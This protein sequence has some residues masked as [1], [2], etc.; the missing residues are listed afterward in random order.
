MSRQDSSK[1]R[2]VK[3]MLKTGVDGRGIATIEKTGTVGLVDTYT[4]TLDDGSKST[5]TVTNGSSIASIEKTSTVGLVDTYTIT[6][7]D[8]S[9]STFTVT[10]GEGG[11]LLPHIIVISET[12]STVTLTK[13][14]TVLT[15]TETTTG[16]F[17]SDVPEFGTWQIDAVLAGDDAQ[18]NLVVD[19]VK[20][21]TVDDSHFHSDI[22]VKY[23]Y[24]AT[25]AL[26]ASGQTTLYATGSPYT[27]TVHSAGT[28]TIT[29]GYDGNNYTDTVEVTT[30][31][32]TF[33]KV[34]PS[35]ATAPANDLNIW[36][37]YGE[38]SGTYST[39][40]DILADS[41]AL[42]TLMA[43]TD[44]VDYLVRCTSWV[45]DITG[46]QSAMSYIGLNNYCANTLLADS[47]WF[48]SIC[49]ST[50]FESVLNVKVPTMTSDTTPSGEASAS[51]TVTSSN[52]YYGFD[53]NS[54]TRWSSN[55]NTT[56]VGQYLRYEF[57]R[58]VCIKMAKGQ[59][60]GSTGGNNITLTLAFQGSNNG[61]DWTNIKSG[62]T[63]V[64][65]T[66]Q[67]T[68]FEAIENNNTLYSQYQIIG[69]AQTSGV[70]L[71]FNELQ[72]YG[73]EDV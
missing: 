65:N 41:T 67:T 70:R 58:P 63:I 29:V 59:Y 18:V 68:D 16:H 61:T 25:C 10:N 40:A 9:T 42:S 1:V 21:Y 52:P 28:Y 31:G 44:A 56:I 55:I 73:R 13:G 15:A 4:I 66:T 24:G 30:T 48:N 5:F 71:T 54:S 23:P 64:H 47:T 62:I 7:T 26:S 60:F 45:S 72:F 8:G 11:G 2:D 43:S 39:L 22:T 32:Q 50:Y 35:S 69:T 33:S 37:S 46:N 38:V 17:E 53:N 19:T 12:G 14:S 6:L 27:F 49:N 34:V 20:I 57:D 36:L 51:S 3:I